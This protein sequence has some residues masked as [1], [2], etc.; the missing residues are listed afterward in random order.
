[1]KD[2]KIVFI[3]LD[4]TLKD[5]NGKV[6]LDTIKS[7]NKLKDK[8][9]QIILTTGRSLKYTI[10]FANMYNGGNYLITSNG[11]EIYNFNS[12]KVLY[13]DVISKEDLEYLDSLISK[14]NLFFIANTINFRYTNKKEKELITK[15]AK[16]LKSI[17]EDISQV[18]I[19][20]Y[21]LDSMKL[22]RKDLEEN[23]NLKISN[24]TKKIIEGK[25]LFYDITNK[26]SSKGNAIKWLCNH[27]NISLD[28]TMAIGDSSNDLEMFNVCKYK[29]AMSNADDDLKKIAS[30]VTLSNNEDGV[31]AVL[32]R[33]YT[34]INS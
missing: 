28:R 24:K 29:I 10:N 1:M 23:N 27:L 17:K 32:D 9:I 7:M 4:G 25:H 5:D 26:T 12:K 11:A 31:K 22:F 6:D 20:S 15:E 14:Y 30:L 3:D 33:L 2:V 18:V 34:E 13:N 19:Q 21:D 8:G 16:D